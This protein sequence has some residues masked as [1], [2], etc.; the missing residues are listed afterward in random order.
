[1]D[2]TFTLAMSDT[3]ALMSFVI[4]QETAICSTLNG[5]KNLVAFMTASSMSLRA[6]AIK[7]AKDA[8][9]LVQ[10][11]GNEVTGTHATTI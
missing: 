10:G 8:G 1:M 3:L 4:M 9:A 6:R 5:F 11:D 7:N 2:S